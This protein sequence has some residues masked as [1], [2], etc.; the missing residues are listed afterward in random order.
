ML[1]VDAT[2]SSTVTAAPP[3]LIVLRSLGWGFM[4][5]SV[6]RAIRR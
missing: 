5:W 4:V 6:Y 2:T 3:H 1:I